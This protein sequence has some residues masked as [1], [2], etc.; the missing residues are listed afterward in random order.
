[1][2]SPSITIITPTTGKKGL[3][4]L[5]DSIEKQNVPYVHILMWDD[6]REDSFLFPNLSD[7]KIMLP[8]DLNVSTQLGYRYSIII[9]GNIIND[10][11]R[12]LLFA[13]LQ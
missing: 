1:M 8:G 7:M 12:D 3:F 10:W 13:Q 9:P 2:T 4:R 5:I 11:Q 6:K